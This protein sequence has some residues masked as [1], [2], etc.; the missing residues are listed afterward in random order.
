MLL[1][2]TDSVQFAF[3]FFSLRSIRVAALGFYFHMAIEKHSEIWF[4]VC[5]AAEA[6]M[7]HAG[8]NHSMVNFNLIYLFMTRHEVHSMNT[9]TLQNPGR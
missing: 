6:Q 9:Q 1:W 3:S 4:F 7:T 2:W 8:A 5:S